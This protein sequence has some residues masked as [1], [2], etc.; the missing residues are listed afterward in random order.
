MTLGGEKGETGSSAIFVKKKQCV[1]VLIPAL[2]ANHNAHC[3]LRFFL[4]CKFSLVKVT[5][6]Q[7]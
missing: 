6:V 5:T 4:A 1:L 7:L 3:L 2:R